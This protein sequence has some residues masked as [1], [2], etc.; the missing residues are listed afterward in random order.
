MG[1]LNL[2]E[3]HPSWTWE[4]SSSRSKKID[5]KC[6]FWFWVNPNKKIHH[7]FS[8]PKWEVSRFFGLKPPAAS[9]C[10]FVWGGRWGRGRG[11]WLRCRAQRLRVSP[12]RCRTWAG[13]GGGQWSGGARGGEKAT[14]GDWGAFAVI[15]LVYVG[16]KVDGYLKNT[17]GVLEVGST[18]CV[19]FP[20]IFFYLL[21][22][23]VFLVW[24]GVMFHWCQEAPKSKVHGWMAR[25]SLVRWVNIPK[26]ENLVWM[27]LWHSKVHL[28]AFVKWWVWR[29]L[30][31]E[32]PTVFP[33]SIDLK[34][35]IFPHRM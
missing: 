27:S 34:G 13:A 23:F 25:E 12:Q 7:E 16:K 30:N 4:G 11:R 6:F 5:F 20:V 18:F 28:N 21:R 31:H 35:Q 24:N 10:F 8:T 1:V 14:S 22:F 17:C 29:W 32:N 3:F 33:V 9:W 26:I 2:R 19:F 15:F